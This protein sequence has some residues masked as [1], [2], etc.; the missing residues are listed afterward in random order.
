MAAS[1]CSPAAGPDSFLLLTRSFFFAARFL[2]ASLGMVTVTK[3]G[4]QTER[5]RD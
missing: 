4:R 5:E 1:D 2:A 3:T